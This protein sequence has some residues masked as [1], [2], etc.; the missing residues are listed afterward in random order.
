MTVRATSARVARTTILVA[1][2]VVAILSVWLSLDPNAYFFY[3][4]QDQS[5]WTWPVEGVALIMLIIMF[6]AAEAI[7]AYIVVRAGGTWRVWQRTL[8]AGSLIVPW[9]FWKSEFVVHQPR[10]FL[11]HIVWLWGVVFFLASSFALSAGAHFVETIR[12]YVPRNS[13]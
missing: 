7:V 12:T 5:Q 1:T 8:L 10:Y 9:A 3:Q 11:L 6:T 2:I 13:V 4:F